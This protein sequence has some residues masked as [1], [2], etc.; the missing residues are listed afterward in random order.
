MCCSALVGCGLQNIGAIISDKLFHIEGTILTPV[1]TAND[2]T[3]Y[4]T[5]GENFN[6]DDIDFEYYEE[7]S[8]S[9]GF[10]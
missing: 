8:C 4:I 2:D 10:H 5:H 9:V 1:E 7:S 3:V 6:Q